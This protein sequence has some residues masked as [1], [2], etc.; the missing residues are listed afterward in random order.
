MQTAQENLFLKNRKNIKDY[1]T[2]AV[3]EKSQ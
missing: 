1:E 2:F 3:Y